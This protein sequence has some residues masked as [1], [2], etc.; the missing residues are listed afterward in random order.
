MKR[1]ILPLICAFTLL[2]EAAHAAWQPTGRTKFA[3]LPT[4][5]T[6]FDQP[7]EFRA[8]LFYELKNTSKPR[9]K[10][11]EPLPNRTVDFSAKA[12]RKI[13][14]LGSAKTD[15]KGIARLNAA[16]VLPA[17][18]KPPPPAVRGTYWAEFQGGRI[19]GVWLSKRKASGRLIVN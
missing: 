16:V 7:T 6:A 12:P 15:K 14:F 19:Q 4:L 3:P 11:W 5:Q 18:Q 10:K 13:Q 1:I 17:G 9:E 2:A 8:R